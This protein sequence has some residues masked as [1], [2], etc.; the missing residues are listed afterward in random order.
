VFL[1]LRGRVLHD[2]LALQARIRRR[3]LKEAFPG[4]NSVAGPVQ[5]LGS[6]GNGAEDVA[7]FVVD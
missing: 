5:S 3:G 4:R 1:Q 2:Y 7:G 6:V